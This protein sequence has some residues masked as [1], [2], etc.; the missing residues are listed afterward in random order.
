MSDTKAA[1]VPKPTAP[2]E[3]LHDVVPTWN[4][5]WN[6]THLHMWPTGGDLIWFPSMWGMLM[7]AV[8]ALVHAIACTFA[9]SAGCI[10]N[11]ICDRN[12]DRQIER[13]KTRPIACGLISVPA[14]LLWL[15]VH[16]LGYFTALSYFGRSTVL[17]GV[18]VFFTVALA[19]P[20]SKRFTDWPQV[21]LGINCACCTLIAWYA[22]NHTIDWT[23]V[24]P[25]SLGMTCWAVHF[26]TIYASSDKKYDKL[27]GVRSCALLFGDYVRP[28]LSLFCTGFVACLAYAGY[29][30][31][32]GPL[33]Y[34]F[35]VGSTALGLLW[36]LVTTL[37]Y[38]KDGMTLF[39]ANTIIGYVSVG[40]LLA[41]YTY[42]VVLR[43]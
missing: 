12:F 22:V 33:Y 14:A 42:K 43:I 23:V 5:Y 21:I 30:N 17:L 27:I 24:G 20:L 16:A 36:Q 1:S 15:E 29:V 28:I 7:I 11:D 41:D 31:R 37:D 10:W 8:H 39:K 34:V 9:H 26:D 3:P 13:S 19:Y 38:A 35:T 2:L 6:L 32:Q 4:H 18:L 25:L 40:G